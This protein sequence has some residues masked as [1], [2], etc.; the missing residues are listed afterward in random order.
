MRL[1][2]RVIVRQRMKNECHHHVKE[3]R[4]FCKARARGVLMVT[5]RWRCLIEKRREFVFGHSPQ[6]I[7]TR[8]VRMC[9][10]QY[11]QYLG[12]KI[13]SNYNSRTFNAS[14]KMRY[15]SIESE[16]IGVKLLY[17]HGGISDQDATQWLPTLTVDDNGKDSIRKVRQNNLAF[18]MNTSL[19]EVLWKV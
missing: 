19:W 3:S 16:H 15:W 14:A 10:P 2:D 11:L 12:Y 7:T 1:Y 13:R 9:Y 8:V 17:D 5:P 18:R 4:T 6:T